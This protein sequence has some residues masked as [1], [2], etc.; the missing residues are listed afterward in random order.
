MQCSKMCKLTRMRS[1]SQMHQFSNKMQQAQQH[2]YGAKLIP[3]QLARHF[4]DE[5]CQIHKKVNLL[6]ISLPEN[7]HKKL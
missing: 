5:T 4:L 3:C 6:T 7:P 2:E 1:A